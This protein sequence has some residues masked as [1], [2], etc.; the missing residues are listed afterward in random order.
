MKVRG[1]G[2]GRMGVCLVQHRLSARLLGAHWVV[3]RMTG[4]LAVIGAP[5]G[6][7]HPLLPIYRVLTQAIAWRV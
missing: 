7:S 3:T 2:V 1:L 5:G 6:G 4:C